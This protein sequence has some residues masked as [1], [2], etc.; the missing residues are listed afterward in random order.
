MR[1]TKL[2]RELFIHNR[3][4]LSQKLEPSSLALIFSAHQMPRNGDQY[5]P[6]R[7]NSDFFYLSGIEQEKSVLLLC[8]DEKAKDFQQI[9]FIIRPD[10]S[11]ETWEG[12]KLT[13]EAAR[14]ISGIKQIKYIDDFELLLHALMAQV[15]NIY[16]N[17]PE[18]PKFKPDVLTRDYSSYVKIKE[19]YPL[20]KYERL[21][22]LICE[23]R[24]I[25]SKEEIEIIRK[26]CS[27]TRDAFIK[28]LKELRPG[29]MEYEAEAIIGFEFTRKG[30]GGHAYQPIVASGRNANT[31]HYVVNNAECKS[32]DLLLLDFGAE[33]ANYAA[34]LSRTIPVN[35]QFTKRQKELYEA[36]LRVFKF[37]RS[38]MK[39]GTTI[40]NIHNDVCKMW[41][42]EH[43]G[44]G[45]YSQKEAESHKGENPLWYNYFMHGTGHFL[46][47][48]VHD[49]GTR[50]T[51]LAPG[52]VLTCEPG[53]YIAEEG[54]GIRIENNILVTETGNI[55]LME[56]IPIEAEEIETLMRHQ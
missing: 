51:M 48:D 49:L 50:E 53:L 31:L 41:E 29:M 39:P 32:G 15:K 54:V 44:L 45:L 35:G 26:A 20:H 52:M 30:A 17:L 6:Y 55:D 18:L 16:F 14:D 25:K 42:E 56:D 9:L 10:K 5:Y 19:Q 24:L 11:L 1:Y 33:Y 46:G 23:M 38:L 2:P 12:K 7:Q 4:K 21:A 36:T 28:L 40:K 22:P 43:I 27:I 13:P 37:A 47:L 34:D 8:N 3:D